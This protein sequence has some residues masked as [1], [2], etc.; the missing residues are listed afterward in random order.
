VLSSKAKKNIGIRLKPAGRV[1]APNLQQEK[2]IES[3][4]VIVVAW[5]WLR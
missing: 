3:L 4:A 2:G 5:E 1:K